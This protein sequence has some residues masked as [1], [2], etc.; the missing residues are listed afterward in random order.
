[1]SICSESV[2]FFNSINLV[3]SDWV[4][5]ALENDD[6]YESINII[7]DNFSIIFI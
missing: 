4:S 3:A 1:M 5:L 6:E 7:I 2:V